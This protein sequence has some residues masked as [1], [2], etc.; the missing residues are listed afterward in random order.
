[1]ETRGEETHVFKI[2]GEKLSI[3]GDQLMIFVPPNY[4]QNVGVRGA[5]A[6]VSLKSCP[7]ELPP[8]FWWLS[9]WME[10]DKKIES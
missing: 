6:E 3:E 5:I 4:R 7:D 8:V 10:P 2:D 1:M 9:N